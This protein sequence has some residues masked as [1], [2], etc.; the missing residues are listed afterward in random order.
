MRG[1]EDTTCEDEDGDGTD[2]D[3]RHAGQ[4]Y[5][6]NMGKDVEGGA[7]VDDQ[8]FLFFIR[9]SPSVRKTPVINSIYTTHF[10]RC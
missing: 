2:E 10:R 1:G 3:D 6:D 5:D 4:G 9:F 8:L 7:G